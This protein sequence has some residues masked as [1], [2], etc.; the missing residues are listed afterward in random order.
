MTLPVSESLHVPNMAR[1]APMQCHVD[2]FQCQGQRQHSESLALVP[3]HLHLFLLLVSP[4]S[5]GHS[6]GKVNNKF[7]LF[8]YR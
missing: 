5:G 3:D 4:R 7:L 2:L 1:S 8:S 6:E